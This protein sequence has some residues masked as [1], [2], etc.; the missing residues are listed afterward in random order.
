MP[1]VLLMIVAFILLL[2]FPARAQE[3]VAGPSRADELWLESLDWDLFDDEQRLERVIADPLEP[4]NRAMF[5]VNDRLYFWAVKP[6]ARAYSAVVPARVR[7]GVGNFFSNAQYPIRLVNNLLQSN[8]KGAL[9]ESERFF[10]NTVFGGL[11]LADLSEILPE[12]R[13]PAVDMGQTLGRYGFGSGIYI[14]W[15]VLG[16]STMRDSAGFVGDFF[17]DPTTYLSPWET[18]Y[19][20]KGTRALNSASFSL[21]EYESIK[22]ASLDPYIAVR[23]GYVQYRQNQV[24]RR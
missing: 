16:P 24:E 21:G 18:A 17:L 7:R 11:G 14:V 4:F 19:G 12:L 9:L 20:V 8:F 13:V 1:S 22:E 23:E 3:P 5:A 2:S 15:P 6:T 10:L